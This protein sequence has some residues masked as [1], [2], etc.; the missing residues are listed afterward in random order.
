MEWPWYRCS[1]CERDFPRSFNVH[2]FE[3]LLDAY[4]NGEIE[5]GSLVENCIW[6]NTYNPLLHLCYLAVTENYDRWCCHHCASNEGFIGLE[7]YRFY[8]EMLERSNQF[9]NKYFPGCLSGKKRVVAP[10]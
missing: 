8:E 9:S 7:Q 6:T 10:K 1:F 2:C 4:A 5:N 3:F